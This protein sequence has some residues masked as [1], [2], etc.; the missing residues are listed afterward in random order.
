MSMEPV[1]EPPDVDGHGLSERDLLVHLQGADAIEGRNHAAR[2]LAVARWAARRSRGRTLS[3][4]DGRGG[5]GVES[6]ALADA[7]LAAVDEDFVAE[8]ALARGCS[9]IAAQRLLREALLLTGPLAPVWSRL[10]AGQ[11]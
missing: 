4:A 9:E 5:P 3:A 8:L 7:V 11:L 1:P 6:R 10:D 2:L